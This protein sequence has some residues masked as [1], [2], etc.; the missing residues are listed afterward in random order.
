M[1]L[2]ALVCAHIPIQIVKVQRSTYQSKN[3]HLSS[4]VDMD[5]KN[6]SGMC[7]TKSFSVLL[8]CP[9]IH[10]WL[11]QCKGKMGATATWDLSWNQVQYENWM[12]FG[13]YTVIN[14]MSH[15]NGD[16]F[17]HR[18]CGLVQYVRTFRY[19]PH[20]IYGSVQSI[21]IYIQILKALRLFCHLNWGI[22]SKFEIIF[23]VC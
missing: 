9:C 3:G 5:F 7:A 6:I 18:Q 1:L 2:S 12:K 23:R 15:W 11:H 21:F 19:K 10:E 14:I 17:L 20:R 16:S 22:H 8:V 4:I 13:Q